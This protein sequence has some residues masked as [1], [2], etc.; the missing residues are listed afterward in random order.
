MPITVLR[1]FQN[2]IGCR[3]SCE[4]TPVGHA[5]PLT[6]TGYHYCIALMPADGADSRQRVCRKSDGSQPGIGRHVGGVLPVQREPPRCIHCVQCIQRVF[7]SQSGAWG[8]A[9]CIEVDVL[10]HECAITG[11]HTSFESLSYALGFVSFV[12]AR[13]MLA[14]CQFLTPCWEELAV[15][16]LTLSPKL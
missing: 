13:F 6:P 1:Y 7:P 15:R 14:D 8:A 16:T 4:S 5:Y 11:Q 3:V 9:C 2:H 10:H 12:N